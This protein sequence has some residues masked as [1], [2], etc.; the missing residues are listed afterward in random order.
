ML[1][2]I[3]FDSL[4]CH[5]NTESERLITLT[6]SLSLLANNLDLHLCHETI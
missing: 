4:Y 3:H 6:I 1:R 2:I 5:R